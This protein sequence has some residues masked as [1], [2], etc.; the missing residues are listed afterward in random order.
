MQVRV[1]P[2]WTSDPD[3]FAIILAKDETA[4]LDRSVRV[5]NGA[6]EAR[7]PSSRR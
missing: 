6:M 7:S 4:P 2:R 5:A 1:L 3:G